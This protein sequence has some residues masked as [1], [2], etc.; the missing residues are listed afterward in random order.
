GQGRGPGQDRRRG[1]DDRLRHLPWRRAEGARRSAEHRRALAPLR[2]PSTQRPEDRRPFRHHD[3]ADEGSGGAA[4]RRR[5]ARHLRL[6][7]VARTIARLI[8]LGANGMSIPLSAPRE[9]K[10]MLH[11]GEELALLDLREEGVFGTGHLLF[12]CCVPLSRLELRIDALVPR[13]STRLVLC[14]GGEGL[15]ERGARRLS[16]LG[17]TNIACLAGGVA[18][19]RAAG[20]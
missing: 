14:D 4:R 17:Y 15:A 19:W 2:L 13:R 1:Q 5:H 16:G 6:S 9:L 7:G 3:R 10:A 18:G 20:Y 11:D 12:A 8:R